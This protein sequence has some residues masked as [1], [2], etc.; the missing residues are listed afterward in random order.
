MAAGAVASVPELELQVE[1]GRLN[2][3]PWK[4]LPACLPLEG[5]IGEDYTSFSLKPLYLGFFLIY[6][7][8]NT[9]SLDQSWKA[10]HYSVYKYAGISLESLLLDL[11]A[12][13][14]CTSYLTSLCLISLAVKWRYQDL[15]HRVVRGIQ[16]V[17]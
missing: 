13:W 8:T 5:S 10:M 15:P 2:L 3:G 16:P 4:T 17:N 12:V 6:N 11:P 7:L 9:P 14:P 1:F